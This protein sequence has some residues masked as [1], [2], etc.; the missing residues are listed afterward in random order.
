MY[1]ET[2]VTL[3]T[4]NFASK[5]GKEL[6]LQLAHPIV[7]SVSTTVRYGGLVKRTWIAHRAVCATIVPGH[8]L[9]EL[10]QCP[11]VASLLPFA[12]HA[13]G[14]SQGMSGQAWKRQV[15]KLI[16]SRLWGL[17][18]RAHARGRDLQRLRVAQTS[19]HDQ[20]GGSDK[21]AELFWSQRSTL[22]AFGRTGRYGFHGRCMFVSESRAQVA[23]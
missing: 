4:R 14:L 6:T 13:G 17:R 7:L 12:E 10:L 11:L 9:N 20:T 19:L 16:R 2:P 22:S 5:T 8:G 18:K 21:K 23:H 1:R 3:T 15:G